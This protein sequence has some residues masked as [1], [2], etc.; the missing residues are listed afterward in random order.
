MDLKEFNEKLN[1]LL[2][3]ERFSDALKLC[4]EVYSKANLPEVKSRALFWIGRLLF[5]LGYYAELGELI[6]KN[7]KEIEAQLSSYFRVRALELEMSFFLDI[8]EPAKAKAVLKKLRSSENRNDPIAKRASDIAIGAYYIKSGDFKRSEEIFTELYYDLKASGK[9]IK[10]SNEAFYLCLSKLCLG[11]FEGF[12]RLL[13]EEETDITTWQDLKTTGLVILGKHA[14]S[15]P[16]LNSLLSQFRREGN[17]KGIFSATC[18]LAVAWSALGAPE[19]ALLYADVALAY[20]KGMPRYLAEAE[21]LRLMLSK[22]SSSQPENIRELR[23]ESSRKGFARA[24]LYASYALADSLLEKGDEDSAREIIKEMVNYIH[25]RGGWGL[26]YFM[27]QVR[28]DALKLARAV[29]PNE[30]ALREASDYITGF[31]KAWPVARIKFFGRCTI[32]GPSGELA[33]VPRDAEVLAFL[34]MERRNPR[35][36][37]D[38]AGLIWPRSTKAKAMRNLY[39]SISRIKTLIKRVGISVP[40]SRFKGPGKLPLDFRTDAE[41]FESMVVAG[42]ALIRTGHPDRAVVFYEK[43]VEIYGGEFLPDS[44]MRWA[45]DLRE[46][47]R[48]MFVE[49]LVFLS[50]YHL[51]A[52]PEKALHYAHRAMEADPLNESACLVLL[53]ILVRIGKKTEAKRLYDRFMEDYRKTIGMESA[54]RWPPE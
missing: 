17:D 32:T 1:P 48:E 41:E 52:S 29:F 34:A 14:D 26:V 18:S 44:R 12:L 2:I 50:G 37:E 16:L 46:L 40:S 7:G 10:G 39:N 35:A 30:K 53:S 13:S 28:P 9:W 4:K 43:A 49:V 24:W 27:A 47:Y 51:K 36:K 25:E 31:Q 6:K 8:G 23:E 15:I 3:E 42:R 33:L 45:Q 19:K 5:R 38:I 11:D 22:E 20:G 21:V 54:I